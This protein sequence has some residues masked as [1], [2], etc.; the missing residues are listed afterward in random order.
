MSDDVETLAYSIRRA[1]NACDA[2]GDFLTSDWLAQRDRETA[3]RATLEIAALLKLAPRFW[4]GVEVVSPSECWHWLGSVTTGTGYG[5]WDSPVG[6]S[7]HRFAWA[8]SNGRII[9]DGM[10]IRHR[11]DNRICC[12][13]GHLELGTQMENVRDMVQRDRAVWSATHC[14]SGHEKT[15]ENWGFRGGYNRC[16]ICAT[17]LSVE[18]NRTQPWYVCWTCD[19]PLRIGSL[20][21]HQARVHKTPTTYAEIRERALP[22]RSTGGSDADE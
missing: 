12:N 14:P 16:F 18:K 15:S 3:A 20:H 7:A 4:S 2:E 17:A 19:K 21:Q 1:N 9:P 6:R 10:V 8:A 5:S 13:P 22:Y 11:C